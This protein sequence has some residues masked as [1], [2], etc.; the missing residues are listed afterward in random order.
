MCDIR[1]SLL[2]SSRPSALLE[3]AS[4]CLRSTCWQALWGVGRRWWPSQVMLWWGAVGEGISWQDRHG[5][6]KRRTSC[7]R[8]SHASN[9]ESLKKKPR[10][11]IALW[12]PYQGRGRLCYGFIWVFRDLHQ[13][14]GRK[15]WRLLKTALT[16]Y[17]G[18]RDCHPHITLPTRLNRVGQV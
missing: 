18:L 2:L 7:C 6:C 10:E 3:L 5:N 11:S 12:R 1:G 13:P 14:L 16:A 8:V 9:Y 17:M 15:A 4:H